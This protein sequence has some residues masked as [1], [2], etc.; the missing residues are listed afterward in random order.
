MTWPGSYS[1]SSNRRVTSAIASSSRDMN[2]KFDRSCDEIREMRFASVTLLSPP[3]A[4][5]DVVADAAVLEF[6]D[7]LLPSSGSSFEPIVVDECV[8]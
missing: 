7:E 5:V 1:T 3:V 6:G 8:K 2:R 4:V